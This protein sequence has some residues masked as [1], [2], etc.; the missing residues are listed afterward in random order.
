MRAASTTLRPSIWSGLPGAD[1][2]RVGAD[3]F[4]ARVRF[5]R[6]TD[7]GFSAWCPT[8][9][10]TCRAEDE[11]VPEREGIAP[12]TRTRSGGGTVAGGD[13]PRGDHRLRTHRH[14]GW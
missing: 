13:H 1:R 6:E 9:Y 2:Q 3:I 4:A 10:P 7:L 8:R 5:R 14:G 12:A 11:R